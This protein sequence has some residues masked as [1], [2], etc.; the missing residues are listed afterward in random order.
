[1]LIEEDRYL[2]HYGVMGMKWGIRNDQRSQG[3]NKVASKSTSKSKPKK[4][5]LTSK[6]KAARNIKITNAAIYGIGA[7]MMVG[8][9]LTSS[10]GQQRASTVRPPRA[11]SAVDLINAR[12]N[13]EVSS[14]IR[15]R[16]EGHMDDDQLKNF[17]SILNARYDRRVMESKLRDK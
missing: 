1:M 17:K 10:A 9:I 6:Q 3:S 2:E 13:T 5:K 4:R 8:A 16:R 11:K 14:L 15:M 12:R 7:A